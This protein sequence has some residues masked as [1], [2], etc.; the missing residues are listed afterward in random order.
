MKGLCPMDTCPDAWWSLPEDTA[1][2]QEHHHLAL[3]RTV[4][5]PPKS[6]P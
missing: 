1:L 6:G 3:R 4:H 5:L 2:Q